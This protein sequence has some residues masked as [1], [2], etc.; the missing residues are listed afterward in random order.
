MAIT[1]NGQAITITATET[2]DALRAYM[3]NN[4]LGQVIDRDIVFEGDLIINAGA[5]LNDQNAFHIFRGSARFLLGNGTT[6]YNNVTIRMTEGGKG[7]FGNCPGGEMNW[8]NCFYIIN[9]SLGRTDFFHASLRPNHTGVLNNV[10][11]VSDGSA[12]MHLY[13]VAGSRLNFSGLTLDC[14]TGCS[15]EHVTLS[16]SV[17]P[18]NFT[19]VFCD[20]GLIDFINLDWDLDVWNFARDNGVGSARF[21]NPIKPA[22]WTGY[23][24]VA[25]F[26]G[27]ANPN[28][29]REEYTHDLTLIDTEANPLSGGSIKLTNNTTS[30]DVYDVVTDVSG[31]MATQNVTTHLYPDIYYNNFNFGAWLYGKNPV[32]GTRGFNSLPPAGSS[33]KYDGKITETLVAIT[34]SQV[35]ELNQS[36]VQAYPITIGI[37]VDT[38]T[39]TGDNSTIQALTVAQLYDALHDYEVI[40]QLR[41]RPA[42]RLQDTLISDFNVI[43]SFISL[44]GSVSLNTSKVLTL[45]N[46]SAVS[47]GIIDSNGDSF[48]TFAGVDSW[49]VYSNQNDA[50]LEQNELGSGLGSEIFR[51][52]FSSS[53]TYFIRLAVGEDTLFK[54]STPTESGETV[55]ELTIAGLLT[56]LPANV[57]KAVTSS[58]DGIDLPATIASGVESAILNDSD[59]QAVISAIVNAIGNTN[60]DEVALVAAIRSDME[61]AGGSLD[62]ILADTNELQTNQGNW[63]TATSVDLNNGAIT[64]NVVAN[65][66]LNNSSFTTGYFNSINSEV[67]TALNDYDAPTKADLDT[68]EANIIAAVPD[69]SGLSTFDP[70]TDTV[71]RVTLVETTTTNTDMRGTDGAV[72]SVTAYDDTALVAKVD[73]IKLKTD[74]LENADLTGLALTTDVTASRGTITALINGLNDLSSTDVT[75]S[76]PTTAD[77]E[78]ALLNEGDSQQLIDA[79]V[80]AIG[81]TDVDEVSL[82][83]AIRADLEREGGMLD[84]LPILSEIEDSSVLARASDISNLNDITAEEILTKLKPDLTIINDGVKQSSLM[85]PHATDLT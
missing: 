54:T 15:F 2:G 3:I 33:G 80:Q 61:R 37:S 29:N 65:N 31:V 50:N 32:I 25:K 39:V 14:D 16:D 68:A 67:D 51:F 10:A 64:S 47:G 75:N 35:T 77:I 63:T 6:N 27:I 52:T 70:V 46:G 18:S 26:G 23:T 57:D 62:N 72:T 19:D 59:G 78:A 83:A 9:T 76:V 66:A 11:L 73:A 60:V 79:I 20:A 56:S 84:A 82:V 38:I 28:A 74:T 8:T 17:F 55:V 44:S 34:D 4:S 81:N 71:A 24:Y 58:V 43:L 30:T 40:N 53:T 69:V 41:V 12:F 45:N 22:T 85:I 5:T 49:K 36:T 13:G 1:N 21:L 7:F 48:L 42:Q